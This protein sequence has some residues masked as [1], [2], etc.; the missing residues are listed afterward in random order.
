MRRI[1][2]LRGVIKM[3]NGIL[4]LQDLLHQVSIA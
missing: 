2:V 4:L 1:L 3:W